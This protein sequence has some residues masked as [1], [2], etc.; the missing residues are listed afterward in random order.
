VVKKAGAIYA[1][2]KQPTTPKG[3][4]LTVFALQSNYQPRIVA[5]LFLTNSNTAK[6]LN[7]VGY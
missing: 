6:Q 3:L 2:F 7:L 1:F 4:S 5:G